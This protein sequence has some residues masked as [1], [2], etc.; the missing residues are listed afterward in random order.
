MTAVY[1]SGRHE[2]QCV[3]EWEASPDAPVECSLHSGYP[4]AR[5][6]PLAFFAV[7]EIPEEESEFECRSFNVEG[8]AP[9]IVYSLVSKWSPWRPV[10]NLGPKLAR[11]LRVGEA[12]LVDGAYTRVEYRKRET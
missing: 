4:P 7:G 6:D 3:I 1:T 5:R 11:R 10:Y 8:S 2:T 9:T 12:V